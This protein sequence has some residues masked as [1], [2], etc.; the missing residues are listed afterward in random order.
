M[1]EYSRNRPTNIV[2]YPWAVPRK[3]DV[4]MRVIQERHYVGYYRRRTR[5]RNKHRTPSARKNSADI[6]VRT[7]PVKRGFVDDTCKD[8]R[9]NA[10]L[11]L[12]VSHA[13]NDP[14]AVR[15]PLD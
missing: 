10:G 4:L 14:A 6:S 13:T 5:H 12:R 7:T 15:A 8:S 2:E 1:P 9:A 3:T 11:E